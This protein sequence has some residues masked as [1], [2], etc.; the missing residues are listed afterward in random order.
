MSRRAR[1]SP[2]IERAEADADVQPYWMRSTYT[3]GHTDVSK[4]GLTSWRAREIITA[5]TP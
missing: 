3:S 1:M 2:L 4:T 5:C